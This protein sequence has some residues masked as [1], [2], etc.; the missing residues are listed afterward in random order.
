M[1]FNKTS[2]LLY[3]SLSYLNQTEINW[4]LKNI[5]IHV[6]C[7]WYVL[8]ELALHKI[9]LLNLMIPLSV[10]FKRSQILIKSTCK[11]WSNLK[12]I[13]NPDTG[14]RHQECCYLGDRKPWHRLPTSGVLLLGWSQTLTQVTDIRS[15]VTWVIAVDRILIYSGFNLV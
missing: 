12:H 14:Y 3:T 4:Y 6:V 9:S 15:V 8:E 13:E 11:H 2:R 5:Y 10:I 7:I 1:Y